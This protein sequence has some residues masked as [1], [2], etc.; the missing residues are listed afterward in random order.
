MAER[1]QAQLSTA[2]DGACAL[3]GAVTFDTVQRLWRQSARLLASAGEGGRITLDLGGVERVDSAGLALLVHWKGQ[4]QARGQALAFAAIP[5]R[6]V[7]IARIS[8]AE[9][10]LDG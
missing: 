3:R 2:A 7:A 6:L 5:P 8:E 9:S 1:A 4:A 10:L